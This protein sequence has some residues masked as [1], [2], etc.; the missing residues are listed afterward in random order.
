MLDKWI[1]LRGLGLMVVD[2]Q[3]E[4]HSSKA[5]LIY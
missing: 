5:M 1:G 4:E 2:I 3:G